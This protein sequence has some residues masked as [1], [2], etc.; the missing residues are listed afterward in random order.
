MLFMVIVGVTVV[1]VLVR[2]GLLAA[3]TL[4]TASSWVAGFP[5]TFDPSAWYFWPGLLGPLLLIAL[6][7]YGF[8]TALAGQTLFHGDQET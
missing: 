3:V 2:V 7:I 1:V 4:S 6:A 8:K 5:T